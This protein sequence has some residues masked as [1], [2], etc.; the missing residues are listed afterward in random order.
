MVYIS[1]A[2]VTAAYGFALTAGHLEKR[3]AARPQVTKGSC[4]FRS[5]PRLGSAC[6][7]F[8]PAPWASRG[9][10][11]SKAKAKRGGLPA[12]LAREACAFLCRSC[13]VQRGCDLLILFFTSEIKRSQ[14]SAAPTLGVIQHKIR[15]T[16]RPPS[17]AGWLPQK[18]KAAYTQALHHS[19]GRALARLPLLIHPP[20]RQAEWRYLSGSWRVA[21]CGAA[22]HI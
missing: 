2:A 9:A 7:R 20:P 18:S 5:V 14:P 12:G 8:G 1:V 15:S 6:P 19:T 16:G 22:S 3:N 21:P 13:R 17:P 11:R 4:P 10:R